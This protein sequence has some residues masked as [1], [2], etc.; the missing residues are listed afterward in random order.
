MRS[1]NG[2][3][4]LFALIFGLLALVPDVRAKNG[5]SQGQENEESKP[6][7]LVRRREVATEAT[8]DNNSNMKLPFFYGLGQ[9]TTG[10]RSLFHALCHINLPSVHYGQWCMDV[11]RPSDM[12]PQQVTAVQAHNE[13]VHKS[14]QLSR[15]AGRGGYHCPLNESLI[16]LHE[17]K[18]AVQRV[19]LS[20]AIS[21]VSD[22]PYQHLFSFIMETLHVAR[23]EF[24][25][26]FLMTERNAQDWATRRL[27]KHSETVVCRYYYELSVFEVERFDQEHPEH[28]PL[29]WNHC[30]Q[31][32]PTHQDSIEPASTYDV[33]VTLGQLI[34]EAQGNEHRMQRIVA[35]TRKAYD[36]YQTR[37]LNLKNLIYSINFFRQEEIL[38]DEQLAS[39]IYNRIFDGDVL[40]PRAKEALRESGIAILDPREKGITGTLFYHKFGRSFNT[41]VLNM[42]I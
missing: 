5:V 2:R 37:S 38:S 14:Y 40:S 41:D 22:T 20:G 34:K 28:D 4:N 3:L 12:T 32:A 18:G 8:S 15:C 30:L 19:I 31:Y 10:T 9:G 29:D 7:K 11:E 23:P 25:P 1:L 17:I 16:L 33:F 21:F 26:V 13:I 27:I 6:Q 36:R 24:E 35:R 39:D 42:D